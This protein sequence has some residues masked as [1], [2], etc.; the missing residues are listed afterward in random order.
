MFEVLNTTF[1]QPMM[2]VPLATWLNQGV[3][4][5]AAV[6][7][8][9]QRKR[10]TTFLDRFWSVENL[11]VQQTKIR[12]AIEHARECKVLAA[13]REGQPPPADDVPREY[14][15]ELSMEQFLLFFFRRLSTLLPSAPLLE[16]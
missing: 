4:V 16:E 10:L 6:M 11:V 15:K 12:Q 1:E 9:L 2:L 13:R 8:E 3:S 14:T 5:S 7:T